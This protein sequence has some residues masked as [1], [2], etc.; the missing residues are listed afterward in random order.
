LV[1][2]TEYPLL[3]LL[4]V[5]ILIAAYGLSRSVLLG[6][7]R[8]GKVGRNGVPARSN[9]STKLSSVILP[10]PANLS[11]S[12]MHLAR[13]VQLKVLSLSSKF[14]FVMILSQSNSRSSDEPAIASTKFVFERYAS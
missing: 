14:H 7:L 4:I 1:T 11:R 9:A 8:F 5:I 12:A 6:E 2:T 13:S 3:P 10:L